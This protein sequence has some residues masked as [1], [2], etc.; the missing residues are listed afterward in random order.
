MENKDFITELE[1]FIQHVDLLIQREQEHL[2][3]LEGLPENT[4]W[5]EESKKILGHY[6]KRR[7]EYQNFINK[8]TKTYYIETQIVSDT[9]HTLVNAIVKSNRKPKVGEPKLIYSNPRK[10]STIVKAIRIPTA[11]YKSFEKPFRKGKVK[12]YVVLDT[13]GHEVFELNPGQHSKKLVDKI[14][15][16]LN[17]AE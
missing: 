4:E 13:N 17:H 7:N 16:T 1:D 5:V 12:T 8:K 3:K 9:N 6:K 10:I 2:Q 11:D 14:I 15:Q